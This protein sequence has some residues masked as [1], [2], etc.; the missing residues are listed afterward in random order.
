MDDKETNIEKVEVELI[1]S[2]VSDQLV[3]LTSDAAETILDS[4]L[5]DGVLQNI[6]VFGAIYKVGK[7]GIGLREQLFAKKVFKFL[8]GIKDITP[9]ERAKFVTDLEENTQQKSGEVILMLLERLDTLDKPPI[10]ANL[11]KSKVYGHISIE[12]FLRLSAIVEKSFLPDLKKLHLYLDSKRY[13]EDVSETLSN[14]GLIYM[15]VFSAQVWGNDE[16]N[17]DSGHKYSITGLGK[18]LLLFGL[19]NNA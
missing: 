5:G 10:I 3:Q 1:N 6:P 15:S 18:D 9:E 7:A 16:P 13:D 12:K 14:L 19:N 8:I 2:M 11:L 4:I 17:P